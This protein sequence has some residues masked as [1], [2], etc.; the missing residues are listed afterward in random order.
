M[1]SQTYTFDYV[2]QYKTETVEDTTTNFKRVSTFYR[3]FNSIDNT[4]ALTVWDKGKLTIIELLAYDNKYYRGEIPTEN[5]F[6][7]A[8]SMKCP[9]VGYHHTP[10]YRPKDYKFINHGDTVINTLMYSRVELQPVNTRR[11][12]K[13]VIFKEIFLIDNSLDFSLPLIFPLSV[14]HKLWEKGV[15]VPNGVIKDLKGYD[16]TGREVYHM[17]LQSIFPITKIIIVDKKNCEW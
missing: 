17:E 3:F 9:R 5:F 6:V 13:M 12:E 1:F 16:I 10:T 11:Y 7:E 2:L 8:L 14:L 15:K 4:S